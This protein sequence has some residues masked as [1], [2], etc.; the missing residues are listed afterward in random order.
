MPV[1]FPRWSIPYDGKYLI[2]PGDGAD[3]T[4]F[5]QVVANSDLGGR[6]AV[7]IQEHVQYGGV[8]DNVPV[9]GNVEVRLSGLQCFDAGAGELIDGLPKEMLQ[10]GFDYPMLKIPD[11][12]DA[13]QE[14]HQAFLRCLR[15]YKAQ[16][17]QE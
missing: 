1:H 5:Q 11:G 16:H 6:Q 13:V 3:Q 2:E 10:P 15:I 7:I 8:E 17:I 9:V 4:R 12:A 14:L